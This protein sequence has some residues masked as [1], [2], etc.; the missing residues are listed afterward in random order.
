MTR[1]GGLSRD[2]EEKKD[3]RE[4]ERVGSR[5]LFRIILYNLKKIFYSLTV[6]PR[7]T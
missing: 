6:V 7:T 1:V 3:L 4:V 2:G 5:P